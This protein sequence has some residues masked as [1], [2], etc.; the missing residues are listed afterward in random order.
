LH[1]FLVIDFLSNR[2]FLIP[3]L[4]VLLKAWSKSRSPHATERAEQIIEQMSATNV[5]P[6]FRSYTGLLICY[7]WSKQPGAP[8]KAEKVLRY[9]DELYKVGH[10]KEG[11]SR[12]TYLSVRKAWD[13]SN[14]PNK[15]N[16]I[17]LLDQEIQNRFGERH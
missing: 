5:R 4:L 11:P 1:S 14:D 8:Q 15:E 2:S 16:A 6:N 3:R 7:S 12:M 17:Q 9:M 10:L 13:V